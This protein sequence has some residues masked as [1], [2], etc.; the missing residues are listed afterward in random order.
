MDREACLQ[1]MNASRARAHTFLKK[2]KWLIITLGTAFSYRL[3]PSTES[4]LANTS[5]PTLLS[6]QNPTGVLSHRAIGRPCLTHFINI[7]ERPAQLAN[8]NVAQAV[9]PRVAREL[10]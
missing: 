3:L 10:G 6:I 5:A 9:G 2:T 4:R 1:G 8:C 7:F